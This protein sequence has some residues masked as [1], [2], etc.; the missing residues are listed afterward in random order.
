MQTDTSTKTSTVPQFD[1]A[2]SL[3]ESRAFRRIEIHD[4]EPAA[5]QTSIPIVRVSEV[6]K[7]V[8]YSALND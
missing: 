5:A 3:N 4:L 6:W 1:L 2:A 7:G 8:Q